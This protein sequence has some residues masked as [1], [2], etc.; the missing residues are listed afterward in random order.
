VSTS[1][2]VVLLVTNNGPHNGAYG[3]LDLIRQVALLYDIAW[4]VVIIPG[5]AIKPSLGSGGEGRPQSPGEVCHS[6][7]HGINMA[8]LNFRF[9]KP[10][11][12]KYNYIDRYEKN[13]QWLLTAPLEKLIRKIKTFT[14][15]CE[16]GCQ[17]ANKSDLEQWQF[18]I[19]RD[20]FPWHK[21]SNNV[22][23]DPRCQD[24]IA[25]C[26]LLIDE[27]NARVT[28]LAREDPMHRIQTGHRQNQRR[29]FMN[30]A[31]KEKNVLLLSASWADTKLADEVTISETIELVLKTAGVKSRTA[32]RFWLNTV[33]RSYLISEMMEMTNFT[34]SSSSLCRE[35]YPLFINR[36]GMEKLYQDIRSGLE[37]PHYEP[38]YD[39]TEMY[40]LVVNLEGMLTQANQLFTDAFII[41]ATL[42]EVADSTISRDGNPATANQEKQYGAISKKSP[43]E[44]RKIMLKALDD[45]GIDYNEEGKQGVSLVALAKSW[46]DPATETSTQDKQHWQ[47]PSYQHQEITEFYEKE[48]IG[49]KYFTG[50]FLLATETLLDFLDKNGDCSSVTTGNKY[51]QEAKKYANFIDILS[52]IPLWKHSLNVAYEVIQATKGKPEQ[53]FKG[54]I[55]ALGHD[56]GKVPEVYEVYSAYGPHQNASL[57]VLANIGPI[58]ELRFF[59]DLK[60]AVMT[61][62]N[63]KSLNNTL[64]NILIDADQTARF[65]EMSATNCK[66]RCTPMNQISTVT[67]ISN[68]QPC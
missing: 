54:V 21:E 1:I 52:A 39:I 36:H 31:T 68:Q 4:M 42:L 13:V 47:P 17:A 53:T 35:I 18:H 12:G 24:K 58:R 27:H 43:E 20:N 46:I 64:Q 16:D 29:S 5:R 14:V 15:E 25:E 48:I 61:H 11:A 60:D 23:N 55:A 45:L 8:I 2:L 22:L 6:M 50:D 9:K 44:K 51:E 38:L 41:G 57:A 40:E 19:Y 3:L 32:M 63:H 62:H 37:N 28:V 66:I 7:A 56:I 33:I 49:R 30:K 34:Q 67:H 59:M 65:K 26:M 10:Q